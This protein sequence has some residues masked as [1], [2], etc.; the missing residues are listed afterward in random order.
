MKTAMNMKKGSNKKTN[1][2]KSYSKYK[3]LRMNM[4]YEKINGCL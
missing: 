2:L 4:K 3:I 1:D